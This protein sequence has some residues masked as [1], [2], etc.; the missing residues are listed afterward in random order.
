MF[1]EDYLTRAELQ[2]HTRLS[3]STIK[4]LEARGLPRHDWA[5][6]IVRYRLS[7]VERWLDEQGKIG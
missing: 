3:R 7:E 6:R 2:A 1:G 5:K 4:R